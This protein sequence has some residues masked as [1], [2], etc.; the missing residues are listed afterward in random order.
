MGIL[1][2]ATVGVHAFLSMYNAYSKQPA[3]RDAHSFEGVLIAKYCWK[4]P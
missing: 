1:G 3:D 4:L 2:F